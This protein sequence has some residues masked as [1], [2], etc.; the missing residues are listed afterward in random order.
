MRIWFPLLLAPIFVLADQS[1]AYAASGWACANQRPIAVHGIHALF[2][3]GCVAGVVMAWQLWSA[4]RRA[5]GDERH[6]VRHFLSGVALASA[7][8][9]SA[10]IAA[11]WLP[12]WLLSPCFN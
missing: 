7:V 2:L 9:S 10:V 6:H 3:I 12:S 11:M 1:I 4:T 5:D 8:L